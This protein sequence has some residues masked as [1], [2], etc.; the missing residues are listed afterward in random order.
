VAGRHVGNL[1]LDPVATRDAIDLDTA[2]LHFLF[3]CVCVCVVEWKKKRIFFSIYILKPREYND[4]TAS[5]TLP[6]DAE[7][8]A[9]TIP[10]GAL[11][12]ASP[13]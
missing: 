4:A 8:A 7:S 2:V 3:V 11:G 5:S 1:G 12:L 9:A 6:L 10:L 13:P